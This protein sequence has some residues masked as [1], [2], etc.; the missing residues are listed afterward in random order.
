MIAALLYY[1]LLLAWPLFLWPAF[2]LSGWRRAWLFSIAAAGLAALLYELWVTFVVGGNIRI[3]IPFVVV[4]LL[5]L[6]GGAVLVL[7][8]SEYRGLGIVV[9]V[10]LALLGGGLIHRWIEITQESADLRATF[11]ERNKL[12]FEAKFRSFDNYA[13]Y[14]RLFDARPT[15]FPVGHYQASVP[16]RFTRL[17]V[18]PEGDAWIFYGCGQTECHYGPNG[19]RLKAVPDGGGEAWDVQLGQ[20]SAASVNLRIARQSPERVAVTVN[21]VET[22]FSKAQPPIAASPAPRNLVYHGAFSGLRCKKA[23]ADVRQIWLWRDGPRLYAVGIFRTL[24]A[25]RKAD[26]LD[27]AL[28]GEA[29]RLEGAGDERWSFAW[30]RNTLAWTAEITFKNSEPTL[31]LTRRGEALPPLALVRRALIQDEAINLAAQSSAKDWRHWFQVVL[32]GHFASGEIP[33]C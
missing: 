13:D 26:Y 14:F 22:I 24:L 12:L 25:G 27:I 32:V 16:G 10:V 29:T 20:R 18:N 7:L 1:M 9:L 4:V 33:A 8:M 6:Y 31:H 23:H 15:P 30:Q 11:E 21:Q 19:Q 3:D 28:L 17:I 5:V 2:R